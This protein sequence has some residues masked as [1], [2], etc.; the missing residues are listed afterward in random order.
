M[1]Y[2]L[3]SHVQVL[4]KVS[5]LVC[6]MQW[7]GFVGL[8][9][10]RGIGI[11]RNRGTR[12][13]LNRLLHYCHFSQLKYARNWCKIWVLQYI[14]GFLLLKYASEYFNIQVL[15]YCCCFSFAMCM[16]CCKSQ[17]LHYFK[18]WM[19]GVLQHPSIACFY[20]SPLEI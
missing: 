13:C 12:Y 9:G 5:F 14:A 15:H 2:S 8:S 3:Y 1:C 11:W 10:R 19:E 18:K 20:C 6:G 7:G 4:I 16:K 17:L